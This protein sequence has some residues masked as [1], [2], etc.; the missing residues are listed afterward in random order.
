LIAMDGWRKKKQERN[1]TIMVGEEEEKQNIFN[2]QNRNKNKNMFR[3]QKKNKRQTHH[4]KKR[5]K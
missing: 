2:V 4:T 5:R 1:L 3:N